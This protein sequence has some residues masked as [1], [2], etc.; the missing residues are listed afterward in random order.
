MDITATSQMHAYTKSEAGELE[1]VHNEH[2]PERKHKNRSI[3]KDETPMNVHRVVTG[4]LDE[5]LDDVWLDKINADNE[6]LRLQKE[7]GKLSDYNYKKRTKTVESYCGGN[8]T[9][10]MNFV[11]T[12]GNVET[13]RQ[14][15]ERLHIEYEMRTYTNEY[16]DKVQEPHVLPKY[17]KRWA[18]F[19]NTAFSNYVDWI[20]KTTKFRVSQYWTHLDEGGAPHVHIETVIAGHTA[21]GKKLSQNSNNA[22]RETLESIGEEISNDTRNNLSKFRK[23]TDQQLVDSFNQTAKEQGYDLSLTLIRTGRPGGQSMADYKKQEAQRLKVQEQEKK[24]KARSKLLTQKEKEFTKKQKAFNDQKKNFDEQ[25]KIVDTASDD[26]ISLANRKHGEKV[27]NIDDAADR[28]TDWVQHNS[29]Y[30]DKMNK[31]HAELER[32]L[33]RQRQVY[34][35]RKQ[36]LEQREKQLDKREKSITAREKAVESREA[37][38]KDLVNLFI[39]WAKT[40]LRSL[41]DDMYNKGY[42]AGKA[43]TEQQ[44]EQQQQIDNEIEQ[45]EADQTYKGL[46]ELEAQQQAEYFKQQRQAERQ[47]QQRNRRE[48]TVENVVKDVNPAVVNKFTTDM[49]YG[50]LMTKDKSKQMKPETAEVNNELRKE[51]E[52]DDDP[53]FEL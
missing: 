4:T 19:C 38:L 10:V 32:K 1:T 21:K 47:K 52:K 45:Y 43:D 22:I 5:T 30:L 12:I 25:K 33:Q 20:N 29:D 24:N 42:Q 3:Q 41:L 44:H 35:Q 31:Q 51:T 2:D 18:D 40:T 34:Q 7:A 49:Y 23:L 14:I 11:S 28:I 37:G 26:L 39:T 46:S 15:M 9:P 13:T 53:G 48:R 27:D 36:E 50:D 8:K 17:Q 16:G 6:K